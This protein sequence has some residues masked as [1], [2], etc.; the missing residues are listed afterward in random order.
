MWWLNI[1]RDISAVELPLRSQESQP[2]TR[3]PW[4]SV[5]EGKVPITSD[6]ENQRR[7]WWIEREG[8]FRFL[9]ILLKGPV[10]ELTC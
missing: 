2:Y 8:Y 9:G 10:H 7:L 5:P 6:C 1:R 3:L 4:I